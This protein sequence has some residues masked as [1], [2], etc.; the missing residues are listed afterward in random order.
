[1]D[2]DRVCR[3]DGFDVDYMK[4]GWYRIAPGQEIKVWS[5]W[6]GGD[7]WFFYAE[8]DD[9]SLVWAGQFHT[10]VPNQAFDNCWSLGFSNGTDLGFRRVR[11]GADIMDY[12]VRLIT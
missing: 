12:T 5:G 8:S 3:A 10:Q 1:M 7:A 4:K 2:E 9:M 6:A 11:P